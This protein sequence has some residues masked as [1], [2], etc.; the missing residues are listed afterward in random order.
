MNLF[1]RL[2]RAGWISSARKLELY[3]PFFVM[4]I[5]VLEIS[6]DWRKVRI[7]LPL[8]RLSRNPGG[9]MFGGYQA[10]LADP[11]AALVCANIFPE[12]SSWTRAMNIDFQHGGSTNLELRFE[13]P[14]EL[15]ASIREEL[16]H[17]D[18]STPTFEYA[19]YL[20]D[21]SVCSVIKNTVAIRPKGYQR[22]TTPPA[23]THEY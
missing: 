1:H 23:G 4:R 16:A 7:C 6:N 3:P 11:I 14:P 20:T 19:Y 13:F 21:G 15:E 17:K 18:R 12:Y 22:A 2:M 5:K 9:V 8:N 10:S